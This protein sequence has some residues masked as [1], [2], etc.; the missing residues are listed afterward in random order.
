MKY[1]TRIITNLE[2]LSLKPGYNGILSLKLLMAMSKVNP[3][4]GSLKPILILR[5]FEN[6]AQ[7]NFATGLSTAI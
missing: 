3:S 5:V 1:L 4:L 7:N 6:Y 2:D